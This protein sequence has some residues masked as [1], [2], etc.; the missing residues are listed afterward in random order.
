MSLSSISGL[1]V[2]ERKG[3]EAEI[4]LRRR[5]GRGPPLPPS[6]LMEVAGLPLIIR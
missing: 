2:K 6:S 1:N 5:A 3:A 4:T